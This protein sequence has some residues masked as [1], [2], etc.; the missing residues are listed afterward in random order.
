[1]SSIIEFPS[2]PGE[3]PF[4]IC[5]FGVMIDSNAKP[6]V[7]YQDAVQSAQVEVKALAKDSDFI[8]VLTHLSAREDIERVQAVPEI[9]LLLGGHEHENCNFGVGASRPY[10]KPMP[11]PA[12]F[13]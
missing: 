11:M 1:M 2:G 6:Y 13:T 4:R 7:R 8:I 9:D 5:L 3:S 12:A 10:L